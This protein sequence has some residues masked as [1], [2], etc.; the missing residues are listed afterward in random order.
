MPSL[1]TIKD[2]HWVPKFWHWKLGGGPVVLYLQQY[3]VVPHDPTEA[4]AVQHSSS[5]GPSPQEE[6]VGLHAVLASELEKEQQISC[7][8]SVPVGHTSGGVATPVISMSQPIGSA[9]V[10]CGVGSGRLILIGW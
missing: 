7:V 1:A 9:V 5:E 10:G 3:P 8:L 6:Q 4:I 2:P